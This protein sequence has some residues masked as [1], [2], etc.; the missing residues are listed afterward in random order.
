MPTAML[1]KFASAP[2]TIAAIAVAVVYGLCALHPNVDG[3]DVDFLEGMI[4]LLPPIV[5]PAVFATVLDG[6]QSLRWLLRP[7]L[8][9]LAALMV[10][11]FRTIQNFGSGA[12]GQDAALIV[13]MT[14]GVVFVAVALSVS[15]AVILAR[16]R[17]AFRD[18]FRRRRLL[19]S[20]LT[21]MAAIPVGFVVGAGVALGL[22]FLGGLWSAFAD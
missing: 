19:G 8:A 17:P 12:R 15:G 21:L 9:S 14:L 18:W 5:V 16:Q 1:R 3:K 2:E 11:A 20:L 22:G 10:S 7:T 6:T 13:V 4:W